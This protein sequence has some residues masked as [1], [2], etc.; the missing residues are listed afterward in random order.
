MVALR[1]VSNKIKS[2]GERILASDMCICVCTYIYIYIYIYVFA[3]NLFEGCC[4]LVARLRS[5]SYTMSEN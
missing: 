4:S 1:D 2:V 3:L 5:Y